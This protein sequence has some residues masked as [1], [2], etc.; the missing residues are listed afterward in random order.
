MRVSAYDFLLQI[1]H[2]DT[3]Q[4]RLIMFAS[5]TDTKL[6]YIAKTITDDVDVMC[7]MLIVIYPNSTFMPVRHSGKGAA[8]NSMYKHGRRSCNYSTLTLCGPL[9]CTLVANSAVFVRVL[10]PCTGFGAVTLEHIFNPYEGT[11]AASCKCKGFGCG[12]ARSSIGSFG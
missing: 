5:R 6:P 1:S 4:L 7:F 12:A 11:I 8:S 2:D 10:A 3:D 9:T